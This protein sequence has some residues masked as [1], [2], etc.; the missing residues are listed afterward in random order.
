[1]SFVATETKNEMTQALAEKIEELR[2]WQIT[3]DPQVPL[4]EERPE[5]A[6]AMLLEIAS[7]LLDAEAEEAAA[8][9]AVNAVQGVE[10]REVDTSPLAEELKKING[11]V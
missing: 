9:A 8:G 10:T 5:D 4:G 7:R 2:C 1:M 6:D 3:S 11:G